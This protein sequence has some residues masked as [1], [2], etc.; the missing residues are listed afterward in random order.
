MTTITPVEPSLVVTAPPKPRQSIGLRRFGYV[1]AIAVNVALIF[2]VNEWPGWATVSFLTPETETV[3]PIINA[4]LVI[5]IVVNAVYLISDPR[6]LRAMGDAVTAAVSFF[7]ILVVMRVFPFD[8]SDYSFD[9]AMLVQV[10]L[11][12]G[13]LGSLVGVIANLVA[14]AR[15]VGRA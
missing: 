14:F 10:M 4:S 8:F 9:W 7:V 13:L 12:V 6:W 5:A 1:V 11:A 15:E 3:I 2:V